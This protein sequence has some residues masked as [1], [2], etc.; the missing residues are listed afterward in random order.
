MPAR[1]VSNNSAPRRRRPRQGGAGT[2]QVGSSR[3]LSVLR[4]PPGRTQVITRTTNGYA[5]L[6]STAGGV[7]AN[8]FSFR[9][10]NFSDWASLSALYDEWRLVG[11]QLDVYC[12][13]ANTTPA[14][15]AQG[16]VVLVY[17]N[18]DDSTALTGY[19]NA[20]DY[21]G[22]RQHALVWNTGMPFTLKALPFSVANPSSGREWA[23][24]ATPHANPCSFKFYAN[25]LTANT[26]YFA[27]TERIVIEFRGQT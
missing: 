5:T 24:T 22:F 23:T 10:D 8:I 15:I 27:T 6:G 11:C 12:V 16:T 21:S 2:S 9:P 18:D 19:A 13:Q 1:R 3:P 17:D 4:L 7:I 26:T 14:T 25:N 20:L